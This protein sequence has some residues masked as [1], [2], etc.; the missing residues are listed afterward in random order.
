LRWTKIGVVV[1]Q[2][3]RQKLRGSSIVCKSGRKQGLITCQEV[4]VGI[5]VVFELER[6][7]SVYSK[8][9]GRGS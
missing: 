7:R 5:I 1:V 8:G 2:F 3:V 9:N 4:Y 6:K